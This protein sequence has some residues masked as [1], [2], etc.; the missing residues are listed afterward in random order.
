MLKL[1]KGGANRTKISKD[2]AKVIN[3]YGINS[4]N[5][6]IVEEH[7]SSNLDK[8]F[9]QSRE[10]LWMLLYPTLNRSLLVS[11]NE[12]T[13]MLEQDRI[14]LKNLKIFYQYE[15]ECGK[16]VPGSE[17]KIFGLK[18]LSRL[19]VVGSG[20]KIIPIEYNSVKGHLSSGLLWKNR[21][22]FSNVQL[23]ENEWVQIELIKNTVQKGVWVYDFKTRNLLAYEPCIKA[24]FTKYKISST[25]FKRIRKFGLEFQGKLFSNKKL[26]T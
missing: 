4:F 11:S 7:L 5:L 14:K 6:I 15:V 1:A 19:G 3:M 17:Q 24:C 26:N 10:Q 2:L 9:V 12:G 20:G 23:I 21:F 13:P 18:S 16:I 25:H 22:L 8:P